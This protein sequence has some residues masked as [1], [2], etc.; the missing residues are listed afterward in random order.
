MIPVHVC[1]LSVNGPR[2]Y[3]NHT[4]SSIDRGEPDYLQIVENVTIFYII[5][6]TIRDRCIKTVFHLNFVVKTVKKSLNIA[7]RPTVKHK[8]KYQSIY[9]YILVELNNGI[10]DRDI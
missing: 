3:L 1:I 8:R 10:L 5:C 4:I 7:V 6:I 9:A 2:K